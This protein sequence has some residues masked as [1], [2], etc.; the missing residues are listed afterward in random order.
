MDKIQELS[1]PTVVKRAGKQGFQCERDSRA[2]LDSWVDKS[3][4]SQSF[5]PELALQ[6][7]RG[8]FDFAFIPS[9]HG[10][11]RS[12]RIH[13][14]SSGAY[15][16]EKRSLLMGSEDS[17]KKRRKMFSSK[18]SLAVVAFCHSLNEDK[19]ISCCF[20]TFSLA[21]ISQSVSAFPF[22]MRFVVGIVGRVF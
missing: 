16:W 14:S 15:K 13:L 19:R 18:I 4:L 17:H 10:A 3:V 6:L 12:V 11:R 22:S 7:F 2:L 9:I 21:L 20:A 5:D 1:R 8:V